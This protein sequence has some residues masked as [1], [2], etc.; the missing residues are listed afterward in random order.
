MNKKGR[1]FVV[2]IAVMIQVMLGI[3]FG[4]TK[5]QVPAGVCF[6]AWCACAMMICKFTE[7]PEIV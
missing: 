3:L 7:A 5:V 4:F 6:L 1:M 2:I